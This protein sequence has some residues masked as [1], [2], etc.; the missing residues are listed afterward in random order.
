M[1]LVAQLDH[2]P[3]GVV[4]LAATSR[5]LEA[6]G[7]VFARGRC[8][9]SLRGRD[10]AADSL[11]VMWAHSYL[12]F[13]EVDAPGWRDHVASSRLYARGL[14]PS[15]LVFR[16][17][18]ISAAREAAVAAGVELTQPYRI[19]RLVSGAEPEVMQYE[20]GSLDSTVFPVSFIR[21]ANPG[22][23]RQ[24]P[25]LDHPN[26]TTGLGRVWLAAEDA[27][28]AR[29]LAARLF[30]GALFGGTLRTGPSSLVLPDASDD[31]LRSVREIHPATG[32]T[33]LCAIELEVADMTRLRQ[34]LRR[35]GIRSSDRHEAGVEVDPSEG[36]GCAIR[37]APAGSRA[38]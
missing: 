17:E 10:F 12:D 4:D 18:S 38:S 14:A 2:V 6:L 16:C 7:F 31:V 22:A 27:M 15:G 37:F 9:W 33:E 23:M 19:E 24:A 29:S 25:W 34:T 20:I 1:Q 13:I 32:R 36:L 30:P 35:A 3:F 28:G 26:T 11:S 8:S 5:M 21:D